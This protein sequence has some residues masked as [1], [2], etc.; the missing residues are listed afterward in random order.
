MSTP[1]FPAALLAAFAEALEPL[2][3]AGASSEGMAALLVDLGWSLDPTSQAVPAEFA[4][5][6][7]S[8]QDLIAR[9]PDLESGDETRTIAATAAAVN[10]VQALARALA[11]FSSL[12]S[13]P[14]ALRDPQLAPKTF[15]VL[16]YRYLEREHPILFALLR[17]IGVLDEVVHTSATPPAVVYVERRLNLDR[18]STAIANPR[19]VPG[20]VYG[21]GGSFD[22]EAL[23]VA[24]ERMVTGFGLRVAADGDAG[25]PL[26]YSAA[27]ALTIRSLAVPVWSGLSTSGSSLAAASVDLVVVPLPPAGVSAGQPEGIAVFP[28]VVGGLGTS[29]PISEG[30]TL[31][32]TGQIDATGAV[33]AELRPSG[34][35]LIAPGGV[36]TS[37]MLRTDLQP[38][39]PYRAIGTPDGSRI[40][41]AKAH[42]EMDASASPSAAELRFELGADQATVVID[43]SQADGFLAEVLGGDAQR[44]DFSLL[45]EWS[46]ARGLLFGGNT[47]PVV[48]LPLHVQLGGVVAVT[49]LHV[50]ARAAS[51]SQPAALD[52][53]LDGNLHLGPMELTLQ[54][55]GVTLAVRQTT[56]GNLGTFDLSFGFK[57]PDGL[58]LTL[59]MEVVSGGGFLAFD[60]RLQQYV[61]AVDLEF[62]QGIR[63]QGI[64]ILSTRAPD[65][66]PGFSLLVL[67]SAEFAVP[68]ELGFGISLVA[69]GG[70]VGLNRT[71][72][73]PGLQALARGGGL[74]AMMFP[75]DLVG[76]APRV[77][78]DLDRYFPIAVNHFVVG[79]TARLTWGPSAFLTADIAVLIEFPAPLRIALL[80]SVH[81]ALPDPTHLI[82]DITL[83]VFGVIDLSSKTI[84]LD[85]GLRDSQLAGFRMSGQAALRARWAEPNPTFV[86]AI[87]GFNP[88]FAVPSG[89]PNLQRI[90]LALGGDNPRLRMSAYFAI[91]SNTLQFGATAD[92]FASAGPA[93]V[94]ASLTFDALIQYSPFLLE[95]DL[96]V[97]AAILFDGSPLLSLRLDLHVSGPDPW[98]ITGSASFHILFATF[99]IPISLTLGPTT[100]A[101]PLASVDLL[102]VVSG[103][104]A[105]L[106]N[107]S[108][109]PPEGPGLV[110]LAAD[111]ARQPD[112]AHPLGT[113]TV[114]ERLAPLSQPIERYGASVLPVPVTVTVDSPTIGNVA[115]PTTPVRDYF[116]VAQFTTLTDAQELSAPSFDPMISGFALGPPGF[117]LP[118][119]PVTNAAITV[120]STR[121]WNT[122]TLDRPSQAS[123]AATVSS[124]TPGPTAVRRAGLTASLATTSAPLPALLASQL[125]SAAAGAA[126]VKQ[127][128]AAYAGTPTGIDVVQPTYSA[129]SSRAG[130][131]SA[132]SAAGASLTLLSSYVDA[133]TRASALTRTDAS[134]AVIFTSELPRGSAV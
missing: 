48:D 119:D 26:Y 76:N 25:L 121:Q 83:D 29:M 86:L 67:A 113:L 45:V 74:D 60:E 82:V 61:G 64:G 90:T 94:S 103:A 112:L 18:L 63:V 11:S 24:L 104:L 66:G 116:G 107:W 4:T 98:H 101:Q 132:V 22:A 110:T 34:A 99:T 78:A 13:L 51:Q 38:E 75:A 44:I 53:T 42:V 55:I 114:R 134:L 7:A 50:G 31:S 97:S 47:S 120:A 59:D 126:S 1:D 93:A 37:V 71:M 2:I 77:A 96:T 133:A 105:N 21:W 32:V 127:G 10:D 122:L 43:F 12:P 39:T 56:T 62:A 123:S 129:A 111:V 8:V 65:G 40:E 23:L 95:V 9:L 92:L 70:L 73:V 5:A 72:N 130:V 28:R 16:V 125:A 54:G 15:G 14:P 80:G 36:S 49:S 88:H 117:S 52:V 58:G 17:L 30:V 131:L 91:T 46:P 33:R 102:Q 84:S 87:G 68:I 100:V 19:G 118:G 109:S 3:E 106:T 20:D 124:A 41:I 81:V 128:A 27:G 69:L 85:A 6:V 89:F 79:P 35:R 57:P 108:A 115:A